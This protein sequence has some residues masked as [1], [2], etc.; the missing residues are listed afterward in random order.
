MRKQHSDLGR[1]NC[2]A[3]SDGDIAKMHYVLPRSERVTANAQKNV[4]PLKISGARL[5][6]QAKDWPEKKQNHRLVV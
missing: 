4:M 6:Y 3:I 1:S 5:F 2:F